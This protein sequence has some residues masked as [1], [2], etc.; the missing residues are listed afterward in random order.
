MEVS[1]VFLELIDLLQEYSSGTAHVSFV[2]QFGRSQSTH[3]NDPMRRLLYRERRRASDQ[4]CHDSAKRRSWQI[5]IS[6]SNTVGF[7]AG[8]PSTRRSS[9]VSMNADFLSYEH[10]ARCQRICDLPID[11][12]LTIFT[13]MSLEMASDD[14]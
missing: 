12:F 3:A 5:L 6:S 14:G 9:S 7:A 4:F 2:Q 1:G 13:A 10:H 8:R 11:P